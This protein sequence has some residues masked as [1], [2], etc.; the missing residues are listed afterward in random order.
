MRG[1][2]GRNFGNCRCDVPGSCTCL[3]LSVAVAVI[4]QTFVFRTKGRIRAYS[5]TLYQRSLRS[6]SLLAGLGHV[7]LGL[8]GAACQEYIQVRTHP[9]VHQV[10]H[11][12]AGASPRESEEDKTSN[13]ISAHRSSGGSTEAANLQFFTGHMANND[14]VFNQRH[15]SFLENA[16]FPLHEH[17]ETFF[18]HWHFNRHPFTVPK[19]SSSVT[20]LPP[21]NPRPNEAYRVNV[22][23][24][25]QPQIHPARM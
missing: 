12:G 7:S 15:S 18:P 3:N 17:I 21:E 9:Q 1:K 20:A 16:L 22:A 11:A 4:S 23:R 14:I 19:R 25:S 10:G 2:E 13:N 5:G 8:V 24:M 6:V